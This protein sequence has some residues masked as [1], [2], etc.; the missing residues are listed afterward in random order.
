VEG[1]SIRSTERMVDASRE[2]VLSL[3]VR[4]GEGCAKV[5]DTMMRNLSCERLELDEVWAFV[6][7]KQRHVRAEDS[8]DVGDTWTYVAIDA[9]T[10]LIPSFLVGKRDA[11]NTSTFVADLATRLRVRPQ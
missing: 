11:T 7:K 9:D 10:K 3:L 8:A 1:C 4:V 5:L 2:T 6:G